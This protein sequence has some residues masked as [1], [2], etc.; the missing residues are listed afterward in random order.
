MIHWSISIYVDAWLSKADVV[1]NGHRVSSNPGAPILSVFAPAICL[2]DFACSIL[3]LIPLQAGR[4]TGVRGHLLLYRYYFLDPLAYTIWGLI[5]S[6][7]SDVSDVTL[8]SQTGMRMALNEYMT[9]TYKFRH[10]FIGAA[11]AILIAFIV[12][13]HLLTAFALQRLNYL[14]R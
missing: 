9:T 6:Q 1:V 8:V 13:F 3:I 11:A 10:A 2:G 12:L 5:G 7:L 4:A 14:K